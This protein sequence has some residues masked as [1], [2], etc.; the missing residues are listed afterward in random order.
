MSVPLLLLRRT[1][2]SHACSQ[3]GLVDLFAPLCWECPPYESFEGSSVTQ[4]TLLFKGKHVVTVS[5]TV[6]C[7]ETYSIADPTCGVAGRAGAEGTT[8]DYLVRFP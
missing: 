6:S 4:Q 8:R 1:G 3:Q 7:A 5:L 2:S